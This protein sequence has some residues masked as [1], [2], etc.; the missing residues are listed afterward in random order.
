[1]SLSERAALPARLLDALSVLFLLAAAA[2]PGLALTARTGAWLPLLGTS[3]ALGALRHLLYP[4]PSLLSR[5][6]GLCGDL[7]DPLERRAALVALGSRLAILVVGGTV[8]AALDY[9]PQPDRYRVSRTAVLNLPARFDAGGYV[10]VARHGYTHLADAAERRR[11]IVFF[12]AFPIAMRLAGEMLMAPGRVLAAPRWLDNDDTR[13][14]WGGVLV[15]LLCFT[16]ASALLVRLAG[17]RLAGNRAIG[18]RAAVLMAAWPFAVPFSAPY[19]EPLF[20]LCVVSAVLALHDGRVWHAGLW[21]LLAGLTLPNGWAL[22]FGLGVALIPQFV[23]ARRA[24]APPRALSPDARHQSWT[25][26]IAAAAAAIG[27]LGFSVWAWRVTGDPLAWSNAISIAGLDAAS[28]PA[29]LG[30]LGMLALTPL[31]A[32][33]A[34]IDLAMFSLAFLAAAIVTS[35]ASMGRSTA[36]LFPVFL[37]VATRLSPRQSMVAAGAFAIYQAWL[38]A[39]FFR[40]MPVP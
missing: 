2:A 40:W 30:A 17:V 32:R 21:G 28:P 19:A 24:G 31:V 13:A 20:L 36:V 35:P 25:V 12:P 8:V 23:G 39:A 1:M 18:L 22:S 29:L 11:R 33:T 7:A 37:T 3:A 10:A 27:T 14:T 26:L 6:A 16:R 34:G 5:L 9:P 38:A 15:A 4:R